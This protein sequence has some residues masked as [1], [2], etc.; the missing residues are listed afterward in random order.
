MYEYLRK[1]AAGGFTISHTTSI[2]VFAG[3]LQCMDG[4]V[5][6]LNSLDC[7]KW[8]FDNPLCMQYATSTVM[9]PGVVLGHKAARKADSRVDLYMLLAL[10]FLTVLCR[11]HV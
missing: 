3:S 2:L 4:N 9:E 10:C 6:L 11:D 5:F 1:A 8:V 7:L